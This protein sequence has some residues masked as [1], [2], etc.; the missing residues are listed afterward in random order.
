MLNNQLHL[1]RLN[2]CSVI[3][4]AGHSPH[5]PSH[6]TPQKKL[7]SRGRHGSMGTSGW[8][9]LFSSRHPTLDPS[10]QPSISQRSNLSEVCTCYKYMRVGACSWKI[11]SSRIRPTHRVWSNHSTYICNHKVVVPTCSGWCVHTYMRWAIGL[12]GGHLHL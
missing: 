4:C 8:Q 6:R 5:R 2:F 10:H 3:P 9:C 12:I 11:D 1:P 7:S